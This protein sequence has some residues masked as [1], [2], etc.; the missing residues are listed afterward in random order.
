MSDE[1]CV[2]VIINE[3]EHIKQTLARIEAQAQKTNGRVSSLE[4]WKYGF[5][6]GIATLAA[7]KWPI[8]GVILQHL[9]G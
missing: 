4:K 3:L 6:V 8:L 5:V 2:K 1:D 7:T 9:G